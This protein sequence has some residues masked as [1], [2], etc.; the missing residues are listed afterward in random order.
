MVHLQTGAASSAGSRQYGDCSGIQAAQGSCT[1]LGRRVCGGCATAGI[2]ISDQ[3]DCRRRLH[4][5]RHSVR[6]HLPA[7]GL[8]GSCPTGPFSLCS[9]FVSL[10]LHSHVSNRWTTQ[11][12]IS[13]VR[14]MMI[15]IS[16][17]VQDFMSS[18]DVMRQT[19]QAWMVPRG[20]PV[21]GIGHSNGALLHLLIGSQSRSENASNVIISYN[22]KC[23]LKAAR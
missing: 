9:F 23:V 6:C 12:M 7:P 21:H 4:S 20:L 1:L 15:S 8:C 17:R 13:P 22:N 5:C 14:R 19:N 10:G 16:V 18:V 2:P 3:V 11:C